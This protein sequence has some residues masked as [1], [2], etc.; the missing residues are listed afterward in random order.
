MGKKGKRASR[1]TV[2][3]A[4][5]VPVS[6]SE[7]MWQKI[8]VFNDYLDDLLDPSSD[9]GPFAFWI[10]AGIL[11]VVAAMFGAYLGTL[12]SARLHRIAQ[13]AMSSTTMA[14]NGFCPDPDVQVGTRVC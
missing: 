11:A 1:T 10:A 9:Q 5:A 3:V 7:W 12:Q 13:E 6:R 2:A 8:G 14:D 4:T